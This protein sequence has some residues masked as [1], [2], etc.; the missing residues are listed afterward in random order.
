MIK[1]FRNIRKKLASENKTAAYSRYALGEIV[2]VVIGILIALQINNWNEHKKESKELNQYL[3]KIA[4]NVKQDIQQIEVLKVRR[5]T[6]RARAI[7]STNELLKQDFSNIENILQGGIVFVEFYFIPNKSG[8]EALKNSPF[9]GKINN[10]K[11]DSLLS[12]YYSRVDKTYNDELSYN[13]FIESMESQ[14]SISIDKTPYFNLAKKRRDN[15]NIDYNEFQDV[16]PY[17]QNNAYKSAMY[18]TLSERTYLVNY[19]RLM[20]IGNAL[21]QEINQF[22]DIEH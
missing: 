14:I 11:V 20:D 10:T 5:D 17:I 9:L 22:C 1:L 19:P 12:V 15:E 4:S 7:R 6:V 16:L 8:F 21:I 18:R 3:Y 2:L 13:N